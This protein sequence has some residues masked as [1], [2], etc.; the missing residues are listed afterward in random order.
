MLRVNHFESPRS[1]YHYLFPTRTAILGYKWYNKLINSVPEKPI[2]PLH[3]Y[4][5]IYSHPIKTQ[6]SQMS[7]LYPGFSRFF[8]IIESSELLRNP[9][10]SSAPFWGRSTPRWSRWPSP[11]RLSLGRWAYARYHPRKWFAWTGR[12]GHLQMAAIGLWPIYM[13]V[14]MYIYICI[15]IYYI[16]IYTYYIYMCVYIC[17]YM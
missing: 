16:Y 11:I 7:H 2:S 9:W 17:M 13:C 10:E 12:H 14:C 5:Y 1:L 3:I 4:I 6:M 8:S 15:Y